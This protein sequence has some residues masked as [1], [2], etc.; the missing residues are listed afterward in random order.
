MKNP[1]STITGVSGLILTG[2]VLFNVITPEQELQL[3]ETIAALVNAVV[4]LIAILGGD[5]G[6]RE[7]GL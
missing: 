4:S 5:P 3:G 7:S 2:L 6:T 1:I